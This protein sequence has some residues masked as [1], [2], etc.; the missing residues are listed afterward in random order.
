MLPVRTYARRHEYSGGARHGPCSQPSPH[1]PHSTVPHSTGA[2]QQTPHLLDRLHRRRPPADRWRGRPACGG[3][4]G[5]PLS[6]QI[7]GWRPCLVREVKSGKRG[8]HVTR[9]SGASST[10][11]NESAGRGGALVQEGAACYGRVDARHLENR[12]QCRLAMRRG[13]AGELAAEGQIWVSN[14]TIEYTLLVFTMSS[15][16]SEQKFLAGSQSPLSI[17][18][19]VADRWTQVFGGAPVHDDDASDGR[20]DARRPQLSGAPAQAVGLQRWRRTK[21][22]HLGCWRGE[23]PRRH[24]PHGAGVAAIFTVE[25]SDSRLANGP[26]RLVRPRP[27]AKQ[28]VGRRGACLGRATPVPP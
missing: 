3:Q 26:P 27:L 8:D 9:R 7:C 21:A 6:A 11:R 10:C 25:P 15:S 19:P 18:H 1:V 28:R 14:E 4:S 5:S 23:A 20:P 16:L 13:M 12:C 17:T 2:T 24:R 22:A